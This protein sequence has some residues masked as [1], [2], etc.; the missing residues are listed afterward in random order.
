MTPQ[1]LFSRLYEQITS[2][3]TYEGINRVYDIDEQQL[4]YDL[5]NLKYSKLGTPVLDSVQLVF[6]N[7]LIGTQQSIN[8]LAMVNNYIRG[9]NDKALVLLDVVASINTTNNIIRT[10]INGFNGT[11][12]EFYNQGDYII[13]LSGS[14][15]GTIPFQD[16]IKNLER[17]TTLW[18]NDFN[19][20]RYKKIIILN[21]YINNSFNIYEVVIT[22]ISLTLNT[23]YSNVIDYTIN[24]ESDADINIISR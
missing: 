6:E 7:D 10:S 20:N 14:L 4:E 24:L 5:L 3:S 18:Q 19:N 16:D 22:D 12:K 17:L 11:V 9:F 1:N 23:E 15:I 2:T 21:R 8:G 13:S